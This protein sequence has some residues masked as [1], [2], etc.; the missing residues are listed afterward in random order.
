MGMQDIKTSEAAA[1]I[2]ANVVRDSE[3][4]VVIIA[5][6]DFT[7]AGFNY[8]SMPPEGNTC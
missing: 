1:A 3:E 7:H 8:N 2:I 6:T 4:D 5:S